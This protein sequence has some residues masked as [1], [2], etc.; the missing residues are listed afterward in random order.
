MQ[1]D[2]RELLVRYQQGDPAAA[3]ALFDRYAGR[4]LALAR[5]RLSPKLAR[6]VDADDVVQSTYRSFFLRAREG[7]FVAENPGDLW[8]LLATMTLH[9]LGRQA[10]RHRAAKR[11]LQREVT[12]V[13]DAP[14][15]LG[16]L[17]DREPSAADV[18]AAAEELHWLLSQFDLAARKA[19]E[20]RLQD[21]TLE[22]IAAS[23]GR[24]ERTIRRWL[25]DARELLTRRW[26]EQQSGDRRGTPGESAIPPPRSLAKAATAP[27][28]HADYHF[29]ALIGSGGMSKVYAATHRASGSRVA[30]KVLR[31]RLRSRPHLVERFVHEAELVA[32]FSHPNIVAVHGLGR[33]PDGNYFMVLDFI[34]AVDLAKLC[35]SE[36]LSADRAARIVAD[37]ADAIQHA[38]DHGVIHRDL[39]PGNALLDRRGKVF[40]T[41]FGFAWFDGEAD[42]LDR[43]IVGTAGFMAPEQIDRSLGKIG[44]ATDVYGLGALL[45]MLC[46]GHPPHEGQSISEITDRGARPITELPPVI[47]PGS[48]PAALRSTCQRALAPDWQLR[49]STAAEVAAALRG[50]ADSIRSDW[51]VRV[52]QRLNRSGWFGN[53]LCLGTFVAQHGLQLPHD[54]RQIS[55]CP[56]DGKDILVR[57]GGFVAQLVCLAFV[58]PDVAHLAQ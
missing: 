24:S 2:S 25:V 22:E 23:I 57:R 50:Y 54:L 48:V 56:H 45:F 15:W 12:T 52:D 33:L 55:L 13:P 41:D 6:R 3:A 26:A 43:S 40:V 17:A 7:E 5:S 30:I 29:E 53:R 4:L 38:H 10:Q 39:K 58:E 1:E 11:S 31:K 42:R 19:I 35:R 14:D 37:V 44:P 28:L 51:A 47:L 16:E 18:V 32:R 27:L 9:K 49:F 8:R 36:Q 21:L 20:L 46:S 34:D